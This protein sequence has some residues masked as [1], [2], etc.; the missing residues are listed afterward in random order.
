MRI[1]VNDI[2]KVWFLKGVPFLVLGLVLIFLPGDLGGKIVGIFGLSVILF[3][4]WLILG[5]KVNINDCLEVS[6]QLKTKRITFTDIQAVYIRQMPLD[7]LLSIYT[8]FVEYADPEEIDRGRIKAF[9]FKSPRLI[10]SEMPGAYAG[11]LSIPG[12]SKVDLDRIASYILSRSPNA[13]R[14]VIDLGIGY[15]VRNE[16]YRVGYFASIGLLIVTSAMCLVFLLAY[17]LARLL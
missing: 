5:F 14:Q 11:I 17:L 13:K 10:Y 6:T 7:K 9:G 3:A 8:L 15:P 12:L 1:N 4:L 16:A 2:Q